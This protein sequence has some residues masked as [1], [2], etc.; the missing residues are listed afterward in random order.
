MRMADL[1]PEPDASRAETKAVA[2]AKAKAWRLEVALSKAAG[3]QPDPDPIAR[4]PVD[5]HP[6]ARTVWPRAPRS[7]PHVAASADAGSNSVGVQAPPGQDP[8]QRR[9]RNKPDDVGSGR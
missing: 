6:P 1:S 5:T 8:V 2:K 7:Q 3:I 9:G 4:R